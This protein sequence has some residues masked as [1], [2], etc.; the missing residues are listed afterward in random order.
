VWFGVDRH[1]QHVHDQVFE[2]WKL[3]MK[4]S[5]FPK[6]SLVVVDVC[7]HCGTDQR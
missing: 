4:R 7:R 3:L 2:L 6:A 5:W 1:E